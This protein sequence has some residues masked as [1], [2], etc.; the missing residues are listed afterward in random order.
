MPQISR[1][2]PDADLAIEREGHTHA[3]CCTKAGSVWVAD[4]VA[5]LIKSRVLR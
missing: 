2:A 4:H 1:W 3:F 5:S